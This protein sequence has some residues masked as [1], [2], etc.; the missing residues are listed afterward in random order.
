MEGKSWKRKKRDW[1]GEKVSLEKKKE[2]KRR[3]SWR[4]ERKS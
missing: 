2:L 4:M 1:E 3:K